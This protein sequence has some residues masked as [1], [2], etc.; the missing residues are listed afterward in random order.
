MAEHGYPVTR[1]DLSSD[2]EEQKRVDVAM[3]DAPRGALL[4][5]GIAVGLLLIGWFFI[6]VFIF[7]PRGTVG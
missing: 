1:H 6:Y 2:A 3:E 7:L 4:V 5:Y